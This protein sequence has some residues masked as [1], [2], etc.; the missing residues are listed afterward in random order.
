MLLSTMQIDTEELERR[1]NELCEQ[2]NEGVGRKASDLEALVLYADAVTTM[3]DNLE[4]LVLRFVL[5]ST[6]NA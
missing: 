6:S 3:M 4:A 1:I 2:T 5:M